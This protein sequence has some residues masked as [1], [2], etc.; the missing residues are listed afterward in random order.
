MIRIAALIRKANHWEEDQVAEE[1]TVESMDSFLATHFCAEHLQ[2]NHLIEITKVPEET[3]KALVQVEVESPPA[4]EKRH[5]YASD[6]VTKNRV[7]ADAIYF[8]PMNEEEVEFAQT[9]VHQWKK[10]FKDDPNFE[11]VN[12]GWNDS[13]M[14]SIPLD[15]LESFDR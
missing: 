3:Q 7:L 5:C 1:L 13:I 11:I 9:V 8:D 12:P 2:L 6:P 15:W 14:D 10:R 4:I